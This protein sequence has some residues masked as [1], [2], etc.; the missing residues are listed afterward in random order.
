MGKYIGNDSYKL[1]SGVMYNFLDEIKGLGDFKIDDPKYILD[2]IGN[3]AEQLSILAIHE[4]VKSLTGDMHYIAKMHLANFGVLSSKKKKSYLLS[5][6]I[7]HNCL[8]HSP[9]LYRLEKKLYT[10]DKSLFG[11]NVFPKNLEIMFADIE[12]KVAECF[13]QYMLKSTEGTN[14]PISQAIEEQNK[15]SEL[16]NQTYFRV[17]FSIYMIICE[18]KVLYGDQRNH[19][20]ILEVFTNRPKLERK[21]V[22]LYYRKWIFG[23]TVAPAEL[24]LASRGL[25]FHPEYD[26]AFFFSISRVWG[27]WVVS[28]QDTSKLRNRKYQY[29]SDVVQPFTQGMGVNMGEKWNVYMHYNI[30]GRDMELFYPYAKKLFFHPE[31][32]IEVFRTVSPRHVENDHKFVQSKIKKSRSK[33]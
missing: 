19:T 31:V 29:I 28:S 1:H 5:P 20:T 24:S 22:G 16:A 7:Y 12:T 6:L 26:D 15:F 9:K 8:A 11:Y 10:S 27:I 30:L 25:I 18:A 3:I 32:D 21:I 13:N 2:L 33:P 23:Y 14:K 17:L 4:E